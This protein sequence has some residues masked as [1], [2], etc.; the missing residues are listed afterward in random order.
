ME[1][2]KLLEKARKE[3]PKSVHEKERFEIPKVKGHIQ[4]T[5]TIIINLYS[6]SN[7]LNR[8]IEHLL[9]FLLK[10]LATPGEIKKNNNAIFG[11]KIPSGDFNSKIKLYADEFVFCKECGK[12]DTEFLK[13]NNITYIKCMVCGAK[14]ITKAKI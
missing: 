11:R 1:Y 3:M 13:E 14:N 5:K 12:P 4:G 7:K 2:E 6:I 8:P 9:K 10:E